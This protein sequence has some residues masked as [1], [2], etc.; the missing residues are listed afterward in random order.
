MGA[1]CVH[2]GEDCG[3][4]PILW[5]E[6]S[7]CC[8]GCKTVY[9]ILN[10][11]KLYSYYDLSDSPGIKIEIKEHQNKYA[12]LDKNEIK[13]KLYEF[14]EGTTAKIN[15]YI[16]S[17]HCASCIWLLE[18]L[19]RL[20]KGVKR[21]T[22]N[23][24]KK[25]VSVTFDENEI[26][27]RRLSEL[28][29]SVHYIPQITLDRIE[30]N[31]LP[32]NNKKLL[33]KIGV[34]GLAFGNTMLFSFPEYFGSKEDFQ[35][36]FGYLNLLFGL[37]VFFYSGSD[38]LLSAVKNL[39]KKIINIDLPV[40]LGMTTLFAQS[41]CEIF[42]QRGAGYID[43][44]TGFIFFLL[45]GK[46]YQ[47]R[48]YKALS[49]D[50]DYKSYFPVAVTV[51]ENDEEKSVLLENLK[52]EQQILIR[53]RELIPA[54]SILLKGSAHIDYSFVTGESKPIVKNI[55]EQIYAGGRQIGEAL[56]LKVL[57]DV[58]QSR[59]TKLWNQSENKETETEHLKTF[60]DRVSRYF[61]IIV[62][63]TA[64]VAG[65]FL[66]YSNIPL[67]IKIFTSV[68]IVACPCALAL[69][70]PFAMGNAM[71]I[72]G[73][74]KFYLK[75]SNVIERFSD[76]DTIVF[77]KTGTLTV[78]DTLQAK[79]EG[80]F[81]TED[82]KSTIKSITRQ[83][84]H[85]LSNAI[86]NYFK[87]TDID[88]VTEFREIP[89]SGLVAFCKGKKV[90]I[91]SR[92][93]VTGKISQIEETSVVFISFDEKLKGFFR[94]ENHYREGLQQIIEKLSP[95]YELHVLSGDNE[96]EK[97]RLEKIF[98][99]TENLR[100]NLTP[101]D[102]A[103]YIQKLKS[104]GKKVLMI[105]DGLNDAGAL[106]ESLVGISIADNIY[107]FSPACD[108]ILEAGTFDK[109][110]EILSYT[111]KTAKVVY[112]S[113]L[114]SI[115]YN[116]VG[117]GF[118]VQGLLSPIVAAILMPASSVTVVGFVTAATSLLSGRLKK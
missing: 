105:G 113:L 55:G 40:A 79:F 34:A 75:K 20:D 53:N 65:P 48:T 26:S 115:L 60:T 13:E 58:K 56:E 83:S 35:Y 92:K 86:F 89:A 112:V 64:I 5:N 95:K 27:L 15:F 78:S 59:L 33:Y 99:T 23:F 70:A 88:T 90:K 14:R 42:T 76:V 43:S 111:K 81:L 100:F 101:A 94:I 104:A 66:H 98:G 82:E 107:H 118:A 30:K 49:F 39:R 106:R 61:T 22:V 117:L 102:K 11:N 54:D 96:S 47:N 50:R 77:D 38:Y 93:F 6:K 8:Q 7:F 91:G 72:L 3:R 114:I 10:D 24:I 97:I 51:I 29:D 4:N 73:K 62:I 45:I 12:H 87:N 108:A 9:Q 74:T 84:T 46:W 21:S 71:G 80:E 44:L 2:C 18:N 37:P 31:A 52:P 16:P 116:F 63:L 19:H 68:L 69:S 32:E 36:V 1:T 17:I 28:L 103:E 110:P 67:S 109:L 41:C 25:E 57:S 85:P